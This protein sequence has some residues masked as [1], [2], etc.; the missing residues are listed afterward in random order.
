MRLAGSAAT[1]ERDVALQDVD[2]LVASSFT[3]KICG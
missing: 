3:Q 2:T 1:D